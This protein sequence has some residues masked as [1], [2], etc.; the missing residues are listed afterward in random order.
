MRRLSPSSFSRAFVERSALSSSR[1]SSS[2]CEKR[3][4]RGRGGGQRARLE[5]RE[6]DRE[7]A[8]GRERN[9][10]CGKDENARRSRGADAPPRGADPG[11][12]RKRRAGANDRERRR[13]RRRAAA[14]RADPRRARDPDRARRARATTRAAPRRAPV[15]GWAMMMRELSPSRGDPGGVANARG[16]AP[17]RHRCSCRPSRSPG[18]C[19][20]PRRASGDRERR[21]A[22]ETRGR[23]WIPLGRPRAESGTPRGAGVLFDAYE[24]SPRKQSTKKCKLYHGLE[25]QSE[26]KEKNKKEGFFSRCRPSSCR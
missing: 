12:E 2:I 7:G 26:K 20:A 3:R 6:G 8:G 1:R 25:E 14:T 13:S 11:R 16:D 24:M 4:T 18:S 22:R 9:E 23:E 17:A 21:R 10:T 5:R 19:V 15:R